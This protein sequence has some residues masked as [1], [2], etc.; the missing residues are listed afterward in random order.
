M[1][2]G[3]L[4]T[5]MAVVSDTHMSLCLLVQRCQLSREKFSFVCT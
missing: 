3:R 4:L 2:G 1:V 5:V